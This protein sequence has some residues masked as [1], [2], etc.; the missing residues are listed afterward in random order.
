MTINYNVGKLGRNDKT[1][2]YIVQFSSDSGIAPSNINISNNIV[3]V[4]GS[5]T[6]SSGNFS[7]GLSVNG[8]GVSIN[9]HTHTA[10]NITDFNTSVSGLLTPYSLSSITLT[11]GS[12]L[13][14]GGN[15]TSNR[16]FDIGAGDGINVSADSIAVN[17]T[18]VRTTGVQTISGIKTFNTDLMY[19]GSVGNTLVNIGDQSRYLGVNSTNGIGDIGNA[20]ELLIGQYTDSAT[21]T[22]NKI[23]AGSSGV[24]VISYYDN[25]QA[26]VS[27]RLSFEIDPSTSSTPGNTRI[28]TSPITG[29]IILTLPSTSGTLALTSNIN[30]TQITGVLSTAK[31][32]T[33][34]SSYSNGQL[35]IGSGTSLVPNTLTAGNNISITP[36]SGTITIS[37]TATGG[38]TISNSGLNRLLTSD[39]S[40]SGI[41]GQ[42]NLT[43][44]GSLL[45]VTG[46]GSFSNNVIASGFVRTN[47]T[48]SQF[49]KADGSV[50]NN[51]Y[52]VALTNPVTGV[53]TSGY[54]SRWNGTNSLTS[55][56][57][58]D[59]GTS[60]GI[61]TITPIGIL[62]IR[63]DVRISGVSPTTLNM[64]DNGTSSY[65]AITM[66]GNNFTTVNKHIVAGFG[67]GVRGNRGTNVG[68]D[69]G[70]SNSYLALAAGGSEKVRITTSGSLGIGTTTPS[71]LLDVTGDVYV[72]GT[73]NNLGTVY[74]KSS[75]SPD[76]S[77]RVRA[78]TNGNLYLDAGSASVKVG[79]QDGAVDIN[80][81]N[82]PITIGQTYNANSIAQRIV[83][84]PAGTETM[85]ITNSGLVGI[86]TTSP[87]GQLHVVGSGRFDGD[88]TATG[89]FIAGS[90]SASL[91]S[92]KFINDADTGLFSPAANT[93]G[94]STS[95]V[96]RLRINDIGNVGI[97]T[98]VPQNGFKLDI[99]GNSVTRGN[100]LSNGN[101][102]EFGNSRY[103]LS[104]GAASNSYSYI[105]NGGGTFGVGFPAPSGRV[106]VSG[107]VAIGSNYNFTP[108]SNGLIIEGNVGVGTTT[109][110]GQFHVVGTGIISSRLGINNTNPQYSLDVSGTG[111]FNSLAISGVP[112]GEI[113][114]DEVA[115]LLVAGSGISLNYN[116][117]VNTLTIDTNVTTSLN[118]GNG[119]SLDYNSSTDTLIVNTINFIHPFLLLGT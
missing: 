16:S 79:N 14:G 61:G 72:R 37:S 32:G 85:R 111:N 86:G 54:V 38:A 2:N 95:G 87:N 73:G 70:G 40:T 101:I 49:L 34:Q 117:S 100:I 58:F 108:P 50:D 77:L 99:A 103:Q 114:D 12:G 110:S 25:G 64:Y 35:L 119:I 48:S 22:N 84:R 60:I 13:V 115:G 113:I 59:N 7:Q 104:N 74:F 30:T 65:G 97:G 36:G 68:M 11:A 26:F 17:N 96:E 29:N 20:T 10:S 19:I 41:V 39:G 93:I 89:S 66:D 53:G 71:G 45:N 116:D 118:G 102:I 109:P 18:V 62:D 88:V 81:A 106:A 56:I 46:S 63:G 15:L 92:Y 94:I 44:N 78:D 21:Y 42:A 9:G 76:T 3:N 27:H 6:A 67:V 75:A 51:S 8:T 24:G 23:F 5:L 33:G 112:I 57:L 107:G 28:R 98:S 82:N 4:S 83:F 105:C 31:G 80:A 91:P 52:Q 55:G 69:S 90:G 1:A 47:G 43:F